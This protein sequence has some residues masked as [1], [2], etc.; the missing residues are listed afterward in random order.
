MQFEFKR[1]SQA[2][3]LCSG[4][5]PE[6]INKGPMPSIVPK[7]TDPC[8]SLTSPPSF[9][10]I[11]LPDPSPLWGSLSSPLSAPE[12]EEEEEEEEEKEKEK[13]E[14]FIDKQRMNVSR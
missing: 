2:P 5:N 12:E 10:L 9:F 4:V 13:E 6:P 8:V 3:Y 11:L 7:I 1:G 14:G